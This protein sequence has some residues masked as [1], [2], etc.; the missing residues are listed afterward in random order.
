[1]PLSFG[2]SLHHLLGN[3]DNKRASKQDRGL[4]NVVMLVATMVMKRRLVSTATLSISL[5]CLST[6]THQISK[7]IRDPR[8]RRS[9]QKLVLVTS[10]QSAHTAR[11]EQKGRAVPEAVARPAHGQGTQYV[12]VRD[13]ND[14]ARGLTRRA[15]LHGRAVIF[16]AD[17]LDQPVQ[18]L[19]D[20]LRAPMRSQITRPAPM[21]RSALV[22][23]G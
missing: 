14:I 19:G 17:I 12:P 16:V 21:H 22:R 20:L 18:P 5:A 8:E 23:N 13:D 9:G 2:P 7:R 6:R 4:A 3:V 1:M 10:P 11:L 15:S